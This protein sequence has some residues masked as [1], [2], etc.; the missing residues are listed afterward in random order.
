MALFRLSPSDLE[1]RKRFLYTF[2]TFSCSTAGDAMN[3][4]KKF[5]SESES[6]S[7]YEGRSKTVPS[8]C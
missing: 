3:S 6:E 8:K 4:E 7:E 2:I 5:V 1:R